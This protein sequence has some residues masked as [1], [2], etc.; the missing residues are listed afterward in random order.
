MSK[1]RIIADAASDIPI[2]D[3]KANGIELVTAIVHFDGKDVPEVEID[4]NEYI[5][6]LLNSDE[7]PTTAA[8]SPT[9]LIECF[10]RAYEDG[11]TD[12]IA[13]TISSTGSAFYSNCF[14][15]KDM[16]C[17]THGE[18]KMNFYFIDSLLYTFCYG[19]IVLEAGKMA[20]SGAS[21]EEVVAFA[22]EKLKSAYGVAGV[23]S[24]KFAKKSGR[25]SGTAAF[26]GEMMGLKPILLVDNGKVNIIEKARGES[27]IIPRLIEA[28]KKHIDP[29]AEQVIR[30]FHGI[31]VDKDIKDLSAA[32][33]KEFKIKEIKTG[34]LGPSL[35]TNA[36]PKV[37]GFTFT[38]KKRD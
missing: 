29:D 22:S 6:F 10:E 1:I 32:L 11:I 8:V 38:G 14:L 17:E 21:A 28:A 35:T 4:K 2:S 16:F 24:L 3:A 30:I 23:Y 5:D 37:L 36:G 34:L 20:V 27:N 19:D 13:I 25:I 26:V 9:Q 7:I 31:K 33:K 15:A 18:G 12:F